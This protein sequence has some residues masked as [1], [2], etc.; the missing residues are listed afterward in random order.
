MFKSPE[1]PSE[2]KVNFSKNER[3][4]II[5]LVQTELGNSGLNE[6]YRQLLWSLMAQLNKSSTIAIDPE[7]SNAIAHLVNL[8]LRKNPDKV[9]TE[10][11]EGIRRK[12]NM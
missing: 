3:K 7:T 4:A 12:F 10:A 9:H 11:Y 6:Q 2:K 1:R 8:E 5:Q